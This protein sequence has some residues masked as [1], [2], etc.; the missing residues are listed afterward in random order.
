MGIASL[1]WMLDCFVGFY[2]TL[3]VRVAA[4][5]PAPKVT[6]KGKGWWARW[7]PSWAVRWGL[8]PIS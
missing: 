6:V 1:V 8:R 4:K 7:R 5:K 3:P 2:L